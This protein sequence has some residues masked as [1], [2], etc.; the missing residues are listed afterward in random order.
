MA[1]M[2]WYNNK[3]KYS[4]LIVPLLFLAAHSASAYV[5]QDSPTTEV[6]NDFILGP[7][8]TELFL[9]PGDSATRE[10][11]VTNRLGRDA[12][13]AVEIEDF[14]GSRDLETVVVLLGSKRG[15]YSL[16]DYLHPELMRFT[17]KHG[18]R[19]ILPIEISVPQDA[20]P[21]GLYGSVLVAAQP[22][23]SSQA[24]EAG[25]ARGG[26]K[27]ITRL[28]SLFLVRVAGD[29]KEDGGLT[30]FQTKL[31]QQFF[32]NGPVTFEI[33]FENNGSVHL[34]PYGTVEFTNLLGKQV[35]TLEVTPWFVMPDSLRARD[36]VWERGFLFGKYT[37]RLK[38]NRG[39]DNAIDELA[40]TF[41]VVP[42]KL[43]SGG[44][45]LLILVIW[46]LKKIFSKFEIRLK[47]KEP[48]QT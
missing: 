21:G 32:E 22:L 12:D 48:A 20:D 41:W 39:Y 8:K 31:G 37:A 46:V 40:T 43:L 19:M 9:N 30:K 17:L 15:P 45:V 36:V 5:I 7:G 25:T 4:I 44:L 29:A 13:F 23:Q 35:G 28:G 47:P 6:K 1:K 2:N 27:L 34:T 38:I 10:I 24:G 18:Q 16:R 33:L 14:T 26:T 3:I 42:W 11:Q